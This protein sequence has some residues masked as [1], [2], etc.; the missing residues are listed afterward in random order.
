[1]LLLPKDDLITQLEREVFDY[2]QSHIGRI[3]EL[4]NLAK[5]EEDKHN[6]QPTFLDAI[7]VYYY[8]SDLLRDERKE[9][10]LDYKT[11]EN[12][13]N[14]YV[15]LDEAHRGDS[16]NSNLKDYVNRLSTTALFALLYR[17]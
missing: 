17:R 5:Y 1:M 15:F 10:I 8:R 13:G 14:W 16:E 4:I 9:T 2:N 6:H 12:D 11:Y 7:K 3:I